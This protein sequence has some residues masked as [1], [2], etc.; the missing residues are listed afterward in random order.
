WVY[1]TKWPQACRITW[2]MLLTPAWW[3]EV[4]PV[5]PRVICVVTIHGVGFQQ[6]PTDEAPGYADGLHEHLAEY[7]DSSLLGDDPNRKRRQRGE[8]G[9]VYVQSSWPITS[10]RSEPGL[11]RLGTWDPIR[12]R[13]VAASRAPL[14]NDGQR[15]AH[16]AL[17]YSHLED[18]GPRPGALAEA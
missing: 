4:I 17:V 1:S 15:I 11:S 18:E 3:R 10:R 12:P 14:T 8:A 2:E 7:L 9:P 13:T 5:S 6:A 16:V